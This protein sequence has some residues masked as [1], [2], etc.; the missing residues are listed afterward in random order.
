[1]IPPAH[2]GLF[3]AAT[4]R[5]RA[6]NGGIPPLP[7]G[8]GS[9]SQ[10]SVAAACQSG[11]ASGRHFSLHCKDRLIIPLQSCSLRTRRGQCQK[12]DDQNA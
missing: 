6:C 12:L 8:R 3:G 1:M 2:P 7:Y 10:Q 5:E 4:V 9:E 11:E